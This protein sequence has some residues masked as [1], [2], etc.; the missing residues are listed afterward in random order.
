MEIAYVYILQNENGSYYVGSTINLDK[1]LRHHFG[2]DTPSTKRLKSSKLVF[3]QK[4]GSLSTARNIERRL[5]R[6]KRRDYLEKIIHDG[7]TKMR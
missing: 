4:Y 6:L 2:G 3:S 1:R 7:V 5:K